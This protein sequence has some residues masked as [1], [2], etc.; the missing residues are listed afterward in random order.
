MSTPMLRI[1]IAGCPEFVRD[2]DAAQAKT[3][4][5]LESKSLSSTVN[6]FCQ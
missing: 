2:G 6:R 5:L 1:T 3:V 4:V